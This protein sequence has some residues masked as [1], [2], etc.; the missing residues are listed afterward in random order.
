MSLIFEKQGRVGDSAFRVELVLLL[1]DVIEQITQG[2]ELAM[3]RSLGRFP[4][5]PFLLWMCDGSEFHTASRSLE[6]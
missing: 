4:A 5:G 1:E 3:A 6:C 2:A